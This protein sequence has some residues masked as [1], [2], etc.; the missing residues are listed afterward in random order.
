MSINDSIHTD[1]TDVS[2]NDSLNARS[3]TCVF[4]AALCA[5]LPISTAFAA[6]LPT[7]GKAGTRAFVL[8]NTYIAGTSEP[9]TCAELSD[10]TTDIFLKTLPPEKREQLSKPER[11]KELFGQIYTT[12]GFK[13]RWLATGDKAGGSA[14][15]RPDALWVESK[16]N[17]PMEEL[18]K[19]AG[20]PE[21][22][23][24]IVFN[25]SALAY[26][27]CT[28]PQDFPAL[29]QGLR[30][31][32]GKLAFGI[33]LD[34]K[35][36]SNKFT[37]P[38]GEKNVNNQLWRALGCYKQFREFGEA[39][40]TQSEISSAAAP[41]LI[42]ISGIDNEVNDGAVEVAVYASADQLVMSANGRPLSNAT[43]SIDSRPELIARTRG[44]I[45]NGVVITEPFDVRMRYKE[46]IIDE[47]RHL[48]GTQL[49]VTL[50]PNGAIEG[51][52]YGYYTLDSFYD[53]MYQMTQMAANITRLSCPAIYSG[54]HKYA[55]GYPDPKTGRNTAISTAMNFVGVS[56]FVVKPADK[57]VATNSH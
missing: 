1:R 25:N 52:F 42:E 46:Q 47:V 18:R 41:T 16:E 13:W 53:S 34:G 15:N 31:Y 45:T 23:G 2:S 57:P 55:D 4:A 32:D 51:A 11:Q 50:K 37:S 56:A 22:K 33:N 38:S 19:A 28:N 39:A 10:G 40:N 43:Y 35:R 30:P 27:S 9:G 24:G 20:I 6:D 5:S 12:Y 21:G 8:S 49:R 14:K 44:S 36:G 3:L 26:D 29:D 54:I 48:R 7:G 17:L